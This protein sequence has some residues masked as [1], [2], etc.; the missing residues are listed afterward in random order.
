MPDLTKSQKDE[1]DRRIIRYQNGEGESFTWE[2][3]KANARKNGEKIMDIQAEKLNLIAWISQLQDTSLITKLKSI[4]ADEA[5]VPEW[6]KDI[7]RDRIKDGKPE[8]MVPWKEARKQL[9]FKEKS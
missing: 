5:A 4:Q 1:L 9:T 2:E 3:V 8:D 7:V 6:Q